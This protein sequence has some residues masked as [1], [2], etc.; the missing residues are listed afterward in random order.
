MFDQVAPF[1]MPFSGKFYLH[2]HFQRRSP[3]LAAG[4]AAPYT[5]LP[6]R[7]IQVLISI[8]RL[9]NLGTRNKGEQRRQQQPPITML[10]NPL[11][12][13]DPAPGKMTNGSIPRA[14]VTVDMKI[15]RTRL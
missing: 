15:C 6:T 8:T 10:P 13:S 2:N 7:P 3:V 11:Y 14:L 4:S 12:S 5:P 1:L 9:R